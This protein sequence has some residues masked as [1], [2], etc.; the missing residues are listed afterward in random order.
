MKKGIFSTEFFIA[1]T[2]FIGGMILSFYPDNPTTNLIG[3]AL[4]GVCGPTYIAGRSWAKG[5]TQVAVE[6]GKTIQAA[7][8]LQE[9]LGK[10][11]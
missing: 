1:I 5:K 7:A 2:G 9:A 8:K 10:K 3:L 11:Q 6:Q 4:A